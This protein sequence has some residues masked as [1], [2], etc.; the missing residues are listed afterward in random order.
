MEEKRKQNTPKYAVTVCRMSC[1]EFNAYFGNIVITNNS[2]VVAKKSDNL[3]RS[4]FMNIVN[5]F[6][7]LVLPQLDEAISIG[8]SWYLKY[9]RLPSTYQRLN[10][11]EGNQQ[12][13]LRNFNVQKNNDT[14]L[15]ERLMETTSLI[16]YR[17]E[18][19]QSKQAIVASQGTSTT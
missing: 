16:P 2:Q 18:L 5:H 6:F 10:L 15:K 4:T 11:K 7:L 17:Y 13:F 19:G 3:T 8:Y 1:S 12:G 14:K 9:H